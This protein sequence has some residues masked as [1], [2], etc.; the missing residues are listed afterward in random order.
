MRNKISLIIFC[1][2]SVLA[3]WAV[4]VSK[5]PASSYNID[6]P[7]EFPILPGIPPDNLPA[8][9][10]VGHPARVPKVDNILPREQTAQLLKGCQ[11]AQ[12]GI[13]NTNRAVIMA[14]V[15]R[16]RG[17]FLLHRG[18]LLFLLM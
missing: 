7:Y 5:P 1:A 9:G 16:E 6:T 4:A 12:T 3:L 2:A 10:A 15:A 8:L 13:K 17:L 18:F 11:A 14:A